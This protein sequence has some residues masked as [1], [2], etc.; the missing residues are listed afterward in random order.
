M[1]IKEINVEILTLQAVLGNRV[2]TKTARA[3]HQNELFQSG[4]PDTLARQFLARTRI[5]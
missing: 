5:G 3:P 1:Q 2:Q 4:E